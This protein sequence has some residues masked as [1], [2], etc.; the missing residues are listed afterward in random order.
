MVM[1]STPSAPTAPQA[2]I[3]GPVFSAQQ[4]ATPRATYAA[5]RE[6]RQ[7]L[8][9]QMSRLLNRRNNVSREIRSTEPGSVERTQ[10][11]QH[12]KE[13]NARIIDME[14]Q[15]QSADLQVSAAAA[16]PGAIA[17]DRV[18]GRDASDFAMAATIFTGIIAVLFTITFCVRSLRRSR[19]KPAPAASPAVDNRLTRMEEAIDAVAIEI[20]RIS[21]SQR[22]LTRILTE[23]KAPALG[24]GAA[25]PIQVAQ[26]EMVRRG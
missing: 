2:P 7:V 20:E 12:L 22:F 18:L 10:L 26:P 21:E 16:M 24:A 11:E 17:G 23:N 5:M 1:Q 9:E 6:Q 8:G 15:I 4:L 14:H 19:E 13:L 3:T 25:E